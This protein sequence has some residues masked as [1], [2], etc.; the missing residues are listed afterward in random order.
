MKQMLQEVLYFTKNHF[1][2][3]FKIIAPYIVA[4]YLIGVV[5]ND[6][7]LKDETQS[8]LIPI[9]LLL[10][11]AIQTLYFGSMIK[12][13]DNVSNETQHSLRLSFSEWQNL[14]LTNFL[15]LIITVIGLFCLIIP[16]LVFCVRFALAGFYCTLEKQDPTE[17]LKS[18]WSHTRPFF[19][20]LLVGFFL[21]VTVFYL[22]SYPLTVAATNENASTIFSIL[23]DLIALFISVLQLILLTV[24]TYR[25][26]TLNQPTNVTD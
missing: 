13:L 21:I 23:I 6:L 2:A 10:N 18:S 16:G 3:I 12:Y 22:F 24:F 17:S 7:L 20:Q 5:V 15:F 8:F 26:Y 11:F 1:T 25:V 9:Y 14:F 19:W 4:L